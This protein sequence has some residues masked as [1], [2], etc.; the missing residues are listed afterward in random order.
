MRITRQRDNCFLRRAE[1]QGA[2]RLSAIS[3]E[4]SNVGTLIGY[5]RHSPNKN[6]SNG[7]SAVS[8]DPVL[9]RRGL[10]R[11]P[12]WAAF[13]TDTR[14]LSYSAVCALPEFESR[15]LAVNGVALEEALGFEQGQVC[16][17]A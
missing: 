11:A 4:Q 5:G 12:L 3:L 10:A 1:T 8:R 9:V 15:E 17:S 7:D 2:Y 13:S 16:R 14:A 6:S